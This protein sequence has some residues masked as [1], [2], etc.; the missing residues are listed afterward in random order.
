MN[1]YFKKIKGFG[2]FFK[3]RK[4]NVLSIIL[5]VKMSADSKKVTNINQMCIL[6][7]LQAKKHILKKK[8]EN[9]YIGFNKNNNF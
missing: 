7:G 1:F 8:Y 3:I 4:Q 9:I 6:F 5:Y 2:Q